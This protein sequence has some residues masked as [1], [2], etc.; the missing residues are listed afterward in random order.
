[1][2]D[3]TAVRPAE[4]FADV[5]LRVAAAVDA[6]RGEILDLS[7]RIHANPEPA[8]E[9]RQASAW[10]AE[11]LQ[12]H[13]F[14]VQYPAGS[15]DTA[16]RRAELAEI[17]LAQRRSPELELVCFNGQTAARA[18]PRWR[19]AGYAVRMLPSSSPAYTLPFADKLAAWRETMVEASR[20]RSIGQGLR[21]GDARA[22]ATPART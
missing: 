3:R 22:P 16:I 4:P 10:V 18:A 2:P 20:L 9:E 15:L 1:M 21:G 6:A 8:F 5:K 19:E 17:A 12:A 14:E 13:G 11:G 7:H